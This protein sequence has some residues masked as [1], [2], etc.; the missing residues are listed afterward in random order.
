MLCIACEHLFTSLPI[1][2]SVVIPHL[3]LGLSLSSPHLPPEQLDSFMHRML[4]SRISRRVLVEHHVAL[5]AVVAKHGVIDSRDRIGIIY[6]N[7]DVKECITQS[8]K[9]LK[10]RPLPSLGIVGVN[11]QDVPWP[12]VIIDG[13]V[14][15]KFA[16]IK[17][18]DLIF[19]Y[20]A[21]ICITLSYRN[22]STTWYSSYLKM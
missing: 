6:P 21:M 14:D 5:S 2:S 20:C 11:S 22:I 12:D 3:S 9:H 7:L 4:V 15:T 16:Y 18:R 13:H 17:V 19:Q 10:A 8:I 1:I